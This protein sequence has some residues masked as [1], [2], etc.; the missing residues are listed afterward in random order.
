M[1]LKLQLADALRNSPV[2]W[3]LHALALTAKSLTQPATEQRLLTLAQAYRRWPARFVER[4]LRQAPP[5]IWREKKIGWMRY[6]PQIAS[7]TL[8]KS[9]ILKAPAGNGE[10]G[11]LYVSFEYNWLRLLE[12]FDVKRLLDEYLLVCASSWSPPDFPAHWALARIGADPVFMQISN[13]SDMELYARFDNGIRPIPIMASDW[14]NPDFY[15]PRPHAKR[16]IDIL[17][18]A[19]WSHVKRHWL[20]FRALRQMRRNLR[21]VLI[22]Q[23]AD[24]RTADDVYREAQAFGVAGRIEMLRDQSIAEVTRHQ[25]NARTSVIL[26]GREG[27]CVVVAE[28]LFADA[29]VAMMENAHIGSR[30]YINAQTGVLLHG[31]TMPTQLGEM[32]ERS[33]SF[34]PRA[35]AM[36]NITC[37]HATRKLSEILQRKIAPM[38]WR[39]DPVYVDAGDNDR[40]APAYQQL[41]ERHGIAVAGHEVERAVS[42]RRP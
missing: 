11:V 39:P 3:K 24:G 22:G 4:Q 14:I 42:S 15:E 30:A 27:S 38:C 40:L 6:R 10:K 34:A 35:W 18:V 25:C 5:A 21:V 23:D 2:I 33:A 13:P 29:P 37:Q 7:P 36:E 26:S 32:I 31:G 20:L 28:S 8:T 9:L 19:G 1:Q 17:M 16:E 12:H 41:L